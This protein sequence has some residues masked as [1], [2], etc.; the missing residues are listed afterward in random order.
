IAVMGLCGL[1]AAS[2]TGVQWVNQVARVLRGPQRL[3]RLDYSKGIPSESRTVI[4]VPSL[5]SSKEAMDELVADLE[6]AYRGNNDH[7]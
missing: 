6:I 2:H 3:P 4:A 5:L 1:I 7:N